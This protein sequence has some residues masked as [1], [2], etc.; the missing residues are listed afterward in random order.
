MSIESSEI[1]L[2]TTNDAE[3]RRSSSSTTEEE[4]RM[5]YRRLLYGS[6]SRGKWKHPTND[7]SA[8]PVGRK[9]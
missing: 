5:I 4:H 7:L 9:S 3:E 8:M 1:A 6:K 2:F